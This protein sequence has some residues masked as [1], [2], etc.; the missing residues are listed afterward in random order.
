METPAFLNWR[1]VAPS[2]RQALA[3]AFVFATSLGIA[4]IASVWFFVGGP[5][6]AKIASNQLREDAIES[7]QSLQRGLTERRREMELAAMEMPSPTG[8]KGALRLWLRRLQ[9]ASPFNS[10]VGFID[11]SGKFVTTSN[12][13]AEGV[14]VSNRDY[15]RIGIQRTFVS[16]AHEAIL[17]ARS[18]GGPENMPRL[19]D[20]A[21]PVYRDQKIVGVLTAHLS[22]DWVADVSAYIAQRVIKNYPGAQFEIRSASGKPIFAAGLPAERRG[23]PNAAVAAIAEASTRSDDLEATAEVNGIEEDK[24]Q[25]WTIVVRA[26][27]S[28]VF[29]LTRKARILAECAAILALGVSAILGRVFANALAAPLEGYVDDLVALGSSAIPSF[30]PAPVRQIND[31]G[32]ALQIVAQERETK[33]L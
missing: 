13:M 30:R 31:I 3:W 33:S 10:L 28:D 26:P 9:E 18:V 8:D 5:T 20:I 7:A 29:A 2:L 4:A 11:T 6:I 24:A 1:Q 32:A 21:T 19:I 22:T 27:V 23:D 12:G 15:F 17:P 14:D 25:N 16:D